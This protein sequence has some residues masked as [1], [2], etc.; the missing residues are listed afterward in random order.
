[1]ARAHLT[2]DL[3]AVAANW[4]AL[5]AL[6][7]PAVETAAVVKADG[8]GLGAAAVGPA[9]LAAGARSFFVALTEEGAALRQA[10]GP[11][12]T[13]Y[14]L[15][16][17]MPGDVALMRA[18]DLVPCLNSPAQIADFTSN[19]PG[20]RH[21]IQLDSGMHRLGL[22]ASDLAAAEG[23]APELIL[24][25]LAC[26]DTPAHPQNAAQARAFA[27]LAA[28][29]PNARRSLAATGGILL[30]ADYHGDLTR[31]G[32]GLFGGLPFAGARPTVT[33]SLPVIQVRAVATGGGVGYGA[34]WIAPRPSRIATVSGGY[35]DGLMRALAG[36]AVQLWAGDRPCPMVGRVS[37]DLITVDVTDLPSV[38]SHLEILN[39][40]QTIDDLAGAAGTIGYEIL[41][42]LGDR[43]DRVYKGAAPAADPA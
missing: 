15:S 39:E 18:N 43:Y 19:L 16:G 42:N 27:N 3:G 10:L 31:P 41:T 8:Y 22:A 7:A 32:I 28:R 2:I 38:P 25:H 35:A 24:S 5:D 20:H 23:L 40:Y 26:A 12:P 30:G 29:L 34:A 13:I 1:M 4:R 33:L 21:A 14:I 37:M 9:L 36:G 17:L 6:S 11:G